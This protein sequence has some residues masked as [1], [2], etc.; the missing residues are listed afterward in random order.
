MGFAYRI[1][2]KDALRGGYGMYYAHVGFSQFVGQ[3]TTGFQ[4]N[5]AA[6]NVTNGIQP[7]FHLDQGFPQDRI[8]QPP[9]LDPSQANGTGV[10][11]VT[12]DGLTLPR[13]QN[14]SV[15]YQHELTSNMM[16]D[17]SYIGNRGSRLN[18]HWERMGV[19]AN[20]NDPSV[21][22]LGT[23]VLQADIDSDLARGAGIQKPY[24]TFTGNVAQ[25]LRA[26]PAVSRHHLARVPP[27]ESQYH[28]FQTVLERR[29]SR[30]CRR[31]SG[32]RSRG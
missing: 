3:P 12:P 10:V 23:P 25:A 6:S 18:H 24:P 17:L 26:V 5:A 7:A 13:F 15:T 14:W 9:S 4:A 31:A 21:L 16:L 32:T 2:E 1:G 30:A 8:V 22:A 11:A 29:F 19:N 20:M 27:G 28:A